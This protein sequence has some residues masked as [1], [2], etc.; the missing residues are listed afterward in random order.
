MSSKAN[1]K[2]NAVKS[3]SGGGAGEMD[4]TSVAHKD[5]DWS[6]DPGTRGT[7]CNPSTGEDTRGDH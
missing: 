1:V 4:D 3:S 5:E 6:S 2:E 7:S